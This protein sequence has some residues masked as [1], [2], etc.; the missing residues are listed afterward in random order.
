MNIYLKYLKEDNM[1]ILTLVLLVGLLFITTACSGFKTLTKEFST[2][3]SILLETESEETE[4]SASEEDNTTYYDKKDEIIMSMERTN[5]LNPLLNNSN[6]INEVL[7]LV[8]LNIGQLT[9]DYK[10][11]LVIGESYTYNKENNTGILV[12]KD[13][14][15]WHNTNQLVDADDLIYSLNILFKKDNNSYYKNV[16]EDIVSY[17]KVDSRTVSFS[18]KE[19]TFIPYFLQFPIIPKD[20]VNS[21]E[22]VDGVHFENVVGNG[23]YTIVENKVN[24]ELV[25]QDYGEDNVDAGIDLI[26][27]IL[28]EKDED[29]LY[30]FESS[31]TNFLRSDLSTWSEY[32]REKEVNIVQENKSNLEFIGFNYNSISSLE[33]FRKEVESAIDFEN[34]A[35]NLFLDFSDFSFSIFPTLHFAYN[36]KIYKPSFSLEREYSFPYNQEEVVVLVNSENDER[37]KIASQLVA[38][39]Q[40]KKINCILKSLPYSEYINEFNNGN[41]TIVLGGS[42]LHNVDNFDFFFG[43][44]NPFSYNDEDMNL[45]LNNLYTAEEEAGFRAVAINIQE[46]INKESILIPYIFKSQALISD[47]NINMVPSDSY[48]NDFANINNWKIE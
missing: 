18:L 31:I 8:F 15:Y 33:G 22:T 23:F 26:N 16:V 47:V 17:K 13:N 19:G 2:T 14:I 35:E 12:L 25:L 27:I 38:N 36:E 5:S 7:S 11:Q 3:D 9:K 24:G 21:L 41:F 37:A 40:T 28:Q 30:A 10:I 45:L 6:R 32:H 42:D 44:N 43:Q 34:V 29:A 20:Y 39:L 1:R 46:K 48:I 4:A